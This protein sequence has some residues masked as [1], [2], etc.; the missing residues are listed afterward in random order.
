M[1]ALDGLKPLEFIAA[2]WVFIPQTQKVRAQMPWADAHFELSLLGP[3]RAQLE[4]HIR[5]GDVAAILN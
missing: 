4:V 5:G 2:R 1:E 3:N